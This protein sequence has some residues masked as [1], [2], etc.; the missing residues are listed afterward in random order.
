MKVWD[1]A[2]IQLATPGS[3][4]YR[5][6]NAGYIGQVV[7]CLTADTSLTFL[8]SDTLPT[9]LRGLVCGYVVCIVDF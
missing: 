8:Q 9:A 7:M 1:R 3:G 5:K 4:Y 6:T 2:G